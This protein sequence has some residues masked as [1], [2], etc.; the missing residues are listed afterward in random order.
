MTRTSAASGRPSS[1]LCVSA[2]VIAS[3]FCVVYA[4]A[5]IPSLR[6]E[7]Q[8][9]P[10]ATLLTLKVAAEMLFSFPAAT[11]ILV[12]LTYLLR[13][14]RSEPATPAVELEDLPSVGVLYLSCGDLDLDAIESLT[15]LRYEG[16]LHLIV[17]D[18]LQ[19]GD[20]QVD[21]LAARLSQLEHCNVHVLRRPNK[22]GGK[23]GAINYVFQQ[24]GDRLDYLLICDNDSTCLDP[25]CIPKLL[26]PMRDPKV[27]VVQCRNVAADDPA[28]CG[29]NRVLSKAIDVF[30]L[31]LSIARKHGWTPFVGHNALL[32]CSALRAAGGFTPGCFADDIDLTVRMNL[33]G[34]RVHYA[35]DVRF[36]EKHPP[37]YTAFRLR[38]YKWAFGSMQVLRRHLGAVLRTNKLS[39]GEKWGFLQFT[40]FYTMQTAL[41]VYVASLYLV[42]PFILS[43]DNFDLRASLLAGTVIPFLIFLPIISFA[44]AH[45]RLRSLPAFL[46]TCWLGYGA[47]DFPTAKG[48]L[49]ALFKPTAKWVPTNSVK[50]GGVSTGQLLEATF[51]VALLVVPLAKLPVLLLSPLTMVIAVK[52]LFIPTMSVLYRDGAQ[53]ATR[54]SLRPL[55]GVMT[56]ALAALLL[57]SCLRGQGSSP[58]Q[59]SVVEVTGK[60][61]S[62]DGEPYVVKGVH[63]GP[64]R[65]GTGPGRSDYPTAEEINSDL[66][67]ITELH[68]NTLLVYDPPDHLVDAAWEHGLRV[69]FA[70][71]IEWP[72]LGTEAF[73]ARKAECLQRVRDLRGHPGVFG[74]M[75]GNEV[76]SWIVTDREPQLV[77]RSLR[78]FYD[79]VKAIDPAHL[80]THANW[81]NT[82]ALDLGFLDVCGFNVYALWPPEVVAQGYGNF[83][84]DE[85]QAL[86]GDRPLLITEYGTNSLEAGEDGQAR[87]TAACWTQLREAEAAGGF[88]FEF[89]DEW[90]KNYSNPK[91]AGAWWDRVRDL[92]DHASHDRDPEEHYGLVRGDRTPKPAFEALANLYAGKRVGTWPLVSVLGVIGA[93]GISLAWALWL[94]GRRPLD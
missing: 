15:R 25:H 31:F 67:I 76:P 10:A 59:Q 79:D 51:G 49:R 61:L 4:L 71:W 26:S 27:G 75:L 30:H 66:G 55:A 37:S 44:L 74:W 9:L 72:E 46:L 18:D 11:M 84:R 8:S 34:F 78:S 16:E 47:T 94:T 36:G 68:A 56:L 77:E 40:G 48:T 5:S 23:P 45:G 52:F 69:L 90:W 33:A 53:P 83:I 63:Y 2:L 35:G 57:A 1:A 28:Y 85:L 20:V 80:V 19:G 70:F 6:L 21:L 60:E 38:S 54:L 12:S 64:W 82:R 50:A 65:P 89:A 73:E 3:A 32:R 43:R 58:T 81:P 88:A 42:G 62:L 7:Q 22:D 92:A 13:E 41:L 93:A 91:L 17:H 86:A 24:L 29:I 87:L 39:L 14:S